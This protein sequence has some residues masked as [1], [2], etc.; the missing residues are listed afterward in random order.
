MT[1]IHSWIN[2]LSY[3][4]GFHCITYLRICQPHQPKLLPSMFLISCW[5]AFHWMN[6]ALEI[7]PKNPGI[8][9]T[10][11]CCGSRK[12]ASRRSII[13]TNILLYYLAEALKICSR[14]V[15]HSDSTIPIDPSL[16]LCPVTINAAHHCT[17]WFVLSNPVQDSNLPIH[18]V[19]LEGNPAVNSIG[20]IKLL[21][22]DGDVF[23]SSRHAESFQ[24][25]RCGLHGFASRL[26]FYRT[27]FSRPLIQ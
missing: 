26:R 15:W 27:T 22:I 16:G 6:T 24:R 9:V 25:I 12:C 7:F 4:E 11:F 17:K 2:S 13:S 10:V 19:H 20:F 5:L 14:K 8:P 23:E 18:N 1:Q 21:I 3:A